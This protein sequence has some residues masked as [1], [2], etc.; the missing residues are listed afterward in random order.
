M[1]LG[2]AGPKREGLWGPAD[3]LP[4]GHAPAPTR[5]T[6]RRYGCGTRAA[7]TWE[8]PSGSPTQRPGRGWSRE[9]CRT[10]G[11]RN[12]GMAQ[13]ANARGNARDRLTWATMVGVAGGEAGR[14]RH[15]PGGDAEG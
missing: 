13:E 6:V 14:R 7:G 12:G 10:A 2:N 9:M 11:P 4:T 15:G 5:R 3:L 1:S 8:P